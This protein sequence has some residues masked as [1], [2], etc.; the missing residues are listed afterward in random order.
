VRHC[1]ELAVQFWPEATNAYCPVSSNV[2]WVSLALMRICRVVRRGLLAAV[3]QVVC[4]AR[5]E[6][7]WAVLAVPDS[8]RQHWP[9]E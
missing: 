9:V 5:G 3:A 4:Q 7:L 6:A 1:P 8:W 2:I